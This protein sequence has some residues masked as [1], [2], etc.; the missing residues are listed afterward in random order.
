MDKKLLIEELHRKLGISIKELNM[1]NHDHWYHGTSYA[2]AKIISS[3]GVDVTYNIGNE[4][5]FGAGF[6][7][8][9]TPERASNYISRVPLIDKNGIPTERTEWAVIDF[10]FNPFDILFTPSSNGYKYKNFPKHN[11][12]FATFTLQNRLFNVYNETPHGYDIIWGVMSD[13]FPDQ[14]ILDYKDNKISYEEAVQKLQKPNSM[15]QLYIANQN[16]CNQLI[17]HDIKT[18]KKEE[19]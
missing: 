7:L 14:V 2:N 8:T 12:E 5:D 18:M 13:S 9:D 10:Q 4:L 1:L 15:K 3:A 16:I 17:I 19:C 11:E 6:Y